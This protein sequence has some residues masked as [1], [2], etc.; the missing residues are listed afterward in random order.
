[1][2]ENLYSETQDRIS[3]NKFKVG[4]LPIFDLH[5]K[6]HQKENKGFLIKTP[7]FKKILRDPEL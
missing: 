4:G 6:A 1:M 7:L 2:I 3:P 5:N